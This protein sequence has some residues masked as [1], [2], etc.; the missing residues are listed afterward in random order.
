MVGA[1]DAALITSPRASCRPVADDH[2]AALRPRRRARDDLAAVG[3][4]SGSRASACGRSNRKRW[5]DCARAQESA[6]GG[7]ATSI[8]PPQLTTAGRIAGAA[9]EPH[10]RTERSD[11]RDYR[12]PEMTTAAPGRR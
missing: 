5:R 8:C 4:R 12:P 1:E 11:R 6:G 2:R 7:R 3:E 9:F 10:T